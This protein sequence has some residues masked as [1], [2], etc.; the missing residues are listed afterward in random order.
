MVPACGC[1]LIS[2]FEIHVSGL[3]GFYSHA[4]SVFY[5]TAPPSL[6]SGQARWAT[7]RR[8]YGTPGNGFLTKS[9]RIRIVPACGWGGVLTVRQWAHRMILAD[10]VRNPLPGVP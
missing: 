3:T 5:P 10:F 8:P 7:V 2:Q 6:R 9:D 4:S 1:G